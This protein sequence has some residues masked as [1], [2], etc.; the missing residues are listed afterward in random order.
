MKIDEMLRLACIYA[1]QDRA[2]YLDAWSGC[3]D[4]GAEKIKSECRAFI[5]KVR[6]YRLKR[7]GKTNLRLKE[8]SQLTF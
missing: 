6:A 7:W 4:D 2:A 8:R 1:E 3:N 5:K